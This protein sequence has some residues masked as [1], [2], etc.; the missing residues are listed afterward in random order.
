[1]KKYEIV[2]NKIK[3]D[4]LQGY[5]VYGQPIDS[6]R[7]SSS[8]F[9][10]S[11]ITIERAY[12]ELCLEGYLKSLPK[13]GYVVNI[14]SDRVTLHNQIDSYQSHHKPKV[15]DYDFRPQSVWSNSFEI[16]TW[17]RYLKNVLEDRN[18]LAS[19]G[20]GQGEYELRKA[21]S[22]YVYKNRGI[23]CTPNEVLI[24]SNYQSLLFIICSL[25]KNVTVAMEEGHILQA[26]KVF[27]SFG[28]QIVY[29]DSDHWFDDLKSH[30]VDVLYINP[31][32]Q[33]KLKRP[34]SKEVSDALL[35]YT[36]LKN[37]LILEDDYNGELTYRSK[38]RQSLY[39]CSHKDNVIYL[40]SFSRLVLPSLRL[41]YVIFNQE[42]KKK[43]L[44][45]SNSYGPS[46]SKI[47][48][49]AFSQYIVDGLLD[50]HLRKL[51]R[52]Y[53]EKSEKMEALL[54]KYFDIPFYLNEAYFAYFAFVDS[55]TLKRFYNL[56]EM[57]KIGVRIQ[58]EDILMIS[59][60]NISLET[61]EEGICLLAKYFE[62]C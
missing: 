35:E 25:L 50:K 45:S 4:I 40:G 5:L 26:Q 41:S 19:Y 54:K 24:G 58:E 49:L 13:K 10:V 12:E 36:A 16:K 30:D 59:F 61:M 60:A 33:S 14:K 21:L 32:S 7:K 57:H 22:S 11:K 51:K 28:F 53:K 15:Y 52:E 3:S 38:P 46:A 20:D 17:N 8:V 56:C 2:K 29:L 27:T 39:S 42:L 6:I 34:I 62:E 37:I 9:N 48:Q 55:N 43:Y 47:E 1:M 44:N 31:A 23:L 18:I